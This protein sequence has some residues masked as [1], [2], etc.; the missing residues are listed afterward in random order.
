M[1]VGARIMALGG[2][3]DVLV[4]GTAAE[5]ARGA[6]F[7][8]VDRGTHV[9]KG[10]EGEWRVVAVEAVDRIRCRRRSIRRSPPNDGPRSQPMPGPGV[11]ASRSAIA[12]VVAV[13]VLG[14]AAFLA[15]RGG[16]DPMIPGP[17]TVAR[18][19]PADGTFDQVVSVGADAFPDGLAA[20]DGKVWVGNV[21]GRTVVQIDVASG[22]SQTF[23]TPSVP[24]GVAAADG[25]T[26]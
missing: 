8:T 13:V 24:T 22:E 6:G 1:V 25:R 5:L 17:D 2:A 11:R 16:D 23:G 19:D 26:G 9:L 15:F 7:G 12:A 20:N 3:G 21:A 10:V 14:A 4:S 18:I